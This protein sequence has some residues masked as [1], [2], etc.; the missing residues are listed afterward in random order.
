MGCF[1]VTVPMLVFT[2]VLIWIVL[3]HSLDQA[4]CPY[5][6]LCPG[7]DLINATTGSDYYVDVPAG[8]LTFIAS[9][10]ST[11]S[12]ILIGPLMT[13]FAYSTARQL[14]NYTQSEDSLK[15][16]PSPYQTSLLIRVLN[17]EQLPLWDIF[18]QKFKGIFWYKEQSDKTEN[19]K[20]PPMLLVTIAVFV[21]CL[22]VR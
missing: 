20:F 14:Q 21:V 16:L 9:W 12:F 11:I 4:S 22:L 13:L 8:Q 17:A 5:S 10:S 2:I 6:D 7:T 18:T 19:L 15:L 1:L 3:A